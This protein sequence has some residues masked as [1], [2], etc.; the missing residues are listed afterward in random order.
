MARPVLTEWWTRHH[1]E[2]A[3]EIER[4]RAE[5]AAL[6]EDQVS[7]EKDQ[8]ALTRALQEARADR[9]RW[10]AEAWQSWYEVGCV[11]EELTTLRA[12]LA[13][14]RPNGETEEQRG[15]EAYEDDEDET[16][17]GAVRL[18]WLQVSG[19]HQTRKERWDGS[20]WIPDSM[21]R[22]V[23]DAFIPC[24]DEAAPDLGP[25][26]PHGAQVSTDGGGT[27]RDGPGGASG[28]INGP[29]GPIDV[30]FFA[31]HPAAPPVEVP[32]PIGERLELDKRV[33][34]VRHEQDVARN[35]LLP[36]VLRAIQENTATWESDFDA[37]PGEVVSVSDAAHAATDVVI[38]ASY[39]PAVVVP[40]SPDLAREILARLVEA[41]QHGGEQWIAKRDAAWAEAREFLAGES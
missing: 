5:N 3:D 23:D 32:A 35:R 29:D 10:N 9:D 28:T 11:A 1:N 2:Q 18:H 31:R 24:P 37:G 12:Q 22:N 19:Q 17:V 8:E 27:W 20:R 15:V 16:P 26:D 39:R 41:D 25:L 14:Q 6:R 34:P 36:I 30:S 4:L 38:A 13:A 40:A 7:Y 33:G 21:W